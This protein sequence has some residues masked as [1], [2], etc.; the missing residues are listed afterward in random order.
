MRRRLLKLLEDIRSS[1]SAIRDYTRS[2]SESDY[3]DNSLVR[4][5]VEREF[6]IIGEAMNRLSREFPDIAN[7]ITGSR[8]IVGFRNVLAHGY[9]I[10]EHDEVWTTIADDVPRLLVEVQ[11]LMD[12]ERRSP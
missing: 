9:D 2:L 5:A 4:R 11:A 12:E 3:L 6:E 1:A 7:R 10:V 8:Q